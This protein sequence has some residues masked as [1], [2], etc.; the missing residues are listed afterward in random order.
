[1][2]IEVEKYDPSHFFATNVK[3]A[4]WVKYSKCDYVAE[5]FRLLCELEDANNKYNYAEKQVFNQILRRKWNW[6]INSLEISPKIRTNLPSFAD[7]NK[8]G[9]RFRFVAELLFKGLIDEEN[10][11]NDEIMGIIKAFEE[12]VEDK[13]ILKQIQREKVIIYGLGKRCYDYF[14]IDHD[15]PT[16]ITAFADKDWDIA[17]PT[18][19][20]KPVISPDAIRN[21]DYSCIA[22][23]SEKFFNEIRTELIEKYGIDAAK[24]CLVSEL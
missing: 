12:K 16:Y 6:M 17:G 5:E 24:I 21:M 22:I 2:H 7:N 8:G 3:L 1:M 15:I 4:Q 10:V 19:W 9:F 18:A 11:S 20:G 14:E 13:P 23:T